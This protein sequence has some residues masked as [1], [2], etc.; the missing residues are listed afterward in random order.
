[1]CLGNVRRKQ[2][3]SN[4][5]KNGWDGNGSANANRNGNETSLLSRPHDRRIG[6]T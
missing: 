2:F 6:S 4:F 1:M 5:D 3:F